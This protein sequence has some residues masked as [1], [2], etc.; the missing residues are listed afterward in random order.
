MHPPA[1]VLE[2]DV[3]RLEVAVHDAVHVAGRQRV[4]DLG[5]EQGGRH[6]G[7]RAVLAQVAVQVRAVDQVH[8]EGEQVALDDEVAGAD[9]VGGG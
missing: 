2:Q 1:L 4:G 8:D 7:E 3:G 6:R 9:D 5:R